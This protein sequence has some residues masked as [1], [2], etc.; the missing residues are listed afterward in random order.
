MHI[1]AYPDP[2]KL[3]GNQDKIRKRKTE[4]V[5]YLKQILTPRRV[6]KSSDEP[7]PR[8]RAT[9]IEWFL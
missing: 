8:V 2:L 5:E 4:M 1:E 7:E 9:E 6:L 3:T